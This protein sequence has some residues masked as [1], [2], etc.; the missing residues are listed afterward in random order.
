MET[1]VSARK[2]HLKENEKGRNRAG[3]GTRS[4]QVAWAEHVRVR[5]SRGELRCGRVHLGE[6]L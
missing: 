6:Q 4:G 5:Q 3:A 1:G 2:D